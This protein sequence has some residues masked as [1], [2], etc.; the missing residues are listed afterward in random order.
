M[1]TEIVLLEDDELALAKLDMGVN[2]ALVLTQ[3]HLFYHRNKGTSKNTVDIVSIS[4]I[5]RCS[6]SS[7][8]RF[9]FVVY[10]LILALVGLI[11]GF[12]PIFSTFGTPMTT[13]IFIISAVLIVVGLVSNTYLIV[14]FSGGDLKFLKQSMKTDDLYEFQAQVMIQSLGK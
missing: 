14:S 6:V 8:K 4:Q 10:G 13:A 11:L 2:G 12:A 1:A 9:R 3:K 5:S 7:I